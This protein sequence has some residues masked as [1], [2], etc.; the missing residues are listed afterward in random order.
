MIIYQPPN[1]TLY[2]VERTF[3]LTQQFNLEVY[4]DSPSEGGGGGDIISGRS[5][6]GRLSVLNVM[7][8]AIKVLS[9]G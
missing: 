7:N 1:N 8:T 6:P 2:S 5:G 3:L 9:K 4:D